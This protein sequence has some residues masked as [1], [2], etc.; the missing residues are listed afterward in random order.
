MT[1]FLYDEEIYARCFKEFVEDRNISLRSEEAVRCAI[2]VY[3]DHIMNVLSD[4]WDVDLQEG[5][6]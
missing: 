2:K 6:I 5:E 1:V 3:T 4:L